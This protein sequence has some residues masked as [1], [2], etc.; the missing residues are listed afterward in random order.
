[1]AIRIFKLGSLERR[2]IPSPDI[3]QKLKDLL[4]SWDGESDLNLI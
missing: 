4:D 2:I 3:L 1:M